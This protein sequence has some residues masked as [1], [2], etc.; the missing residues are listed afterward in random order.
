MVSQGLVVSAGVSSE[1]SLITKVSTNF[2]SVVSAI[3]VDGAT[4]QLPDIIIDFN[5]STITSLGQLQA[6]F[7][8]MFIRAAASAGLTH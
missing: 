5:A 3:V 7:N 8:D 2:S 6:A 4:F 1:V